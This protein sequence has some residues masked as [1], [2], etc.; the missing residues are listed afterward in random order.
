MVLP[1]IIIN[2]YCAELDYTL[3]ER[4]GKMKGKRAKNF[5]WCFTNAESPVVSF[6]TFVV[7]VRNPYGTG[8]TR[9]YQAE[10]SPSSP[11]SPSSKRVF[12]SIN[13]PT[14]LV[15]PSNFVPF[16]HKLW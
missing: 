2:L 13:N 16:L 5:G 7:L 1:T 6:V 8:K 11:R 4:L 12:C 9:N 15:P 10:F 3:R 14:S